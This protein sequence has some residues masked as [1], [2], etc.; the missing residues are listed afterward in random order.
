[1]V[2]WPFLC[3]SPSSVIR[4]VKTNRLFSQVSVFYRGLSI[5]LSYN[6][7]LIHVKLCSKDPLHAT[8]SA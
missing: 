6:V 3:A 1:M 5:G 2:G 8:V 7:I 4:I